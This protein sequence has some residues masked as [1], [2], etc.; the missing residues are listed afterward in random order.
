MQDAYHLP[1]TPEDVDWGLIKKSDAYVIPAVF[2]VL[3]IAMTVPAVA[4]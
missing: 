4:F 1:M 2:G 3:G